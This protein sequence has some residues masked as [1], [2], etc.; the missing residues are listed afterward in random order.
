LKIQND[1]VV[2][3]HYT[4][5]DAAGTTL[6][7]SEADDPLE[8]LHGHGNIVPGLEAALTGAEPGR[9]LDVEV[10][11]EAGYGP[12]DEEAVIKIGR[13]R[14]PKEFAPEVGMQLASR[15][16]DG[17]VVRMQ[18]TAVGP[19]E[20]T[21]DLNHPL[22]GKTLHFAVEVADVREATPE[23]LSHGHGHGAGHCCGDARDRDGCDSHGGC[24]GC[25]G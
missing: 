21:A 7:A 12:R 17:H 5:R 10:P 14:F 3:I 18:I 2:R 24:G 20:V 25:H 15:T 13:D 23:E 11:P 9:K 19:D 6:D 8:Y 22:A 1:R 4:L 16:S